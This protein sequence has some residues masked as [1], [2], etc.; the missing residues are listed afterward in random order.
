MTHFGPMPDS[1]GIFTLE[2]ESLT[3]ETAKYLRHCNKCGKEQTHTC[4]RWESH[5]GGYTDYRYTCVVCGAIH[6]VDGIDS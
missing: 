4:E 3:K 2:T 6:W 5:C 1:A